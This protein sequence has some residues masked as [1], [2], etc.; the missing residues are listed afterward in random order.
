VSDAA[1]SLT[2]MT[3]T[4]TAWDDREGVIDDDRAYAGSTYREIVDAI[5]A[6]PYQRVWGA[7]GEPPLPR[8]QVTLASVV[9]GL[10]RA[11]SIALL[12][13]SGRTVDSGAD[14]RWGPDGRGFRRLLHPNGIC[15]TGRWSITEPSPYSGYFS[16]GRT[17][18]VIARYSTCCNETQR[19]FM[20]SLSL[21]AKILPTTDPND[22]ARLRPASLITQ[23]DIGG[24]RTDYINDAE[25][26]TAPDTTVLRRGAGVPVILVTGL[27]L[28][29]ADRMPSIR[30]VYEIAELGKPPN[31]PT[32]APAFLRLLVAP[33]QPRISGDHLDFRD[34]IMAQ[35]YDAGD[36]TPKRTLRFGI[37]VTDDGTTRGSKLR[38]RRTFT[39]WRRVGTLEFDRAVVSYNGDSVIHFHHPTWRD[40]RNDPATATRVDGRKV[41]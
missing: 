29:R 20:R 31:E 23:Q 9:A 1:A 6:N 7:S 33:D 32:R 25:L 11:G 41:R 16:T 19:G 14:L 10:A 39:N 27:A 15:L 40:D 8:Y 13:A 38:E 35:I 2:A 26:R 34:E 5:F 17:G 18:L 4:S 22:P 30:Q 3:N 21:V 37:E 12:R 36:P 24:D 28:G